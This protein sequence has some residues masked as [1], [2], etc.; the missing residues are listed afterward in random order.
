MSVDVLV[1]Q[2]SN[3]RVLTPYLAP[4]RP[5]RSHAAKPS[6]AGEP[7]LTTEPLANFVV[8]RDDVGITEGMQEP[9]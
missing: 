6:P 1:E 5:M 7:L 8:F 3:W 2:T 4:P 9:T